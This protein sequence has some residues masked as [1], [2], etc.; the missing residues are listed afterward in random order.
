MKTEKISRGLAALLKKS[1]FI[2]VGTSDASGSPSVASKFLLKVDGNTVYLVD[3]IKGKTLRNVRYNPI[4]SLSVMDEDN[5]RGYQI[6]GTVSVIEFGKEFD[7]L[8]L[9]FTEKQVSFATNRIIAGVQQS[10]PHAGAVFSSNKAEVFYRISVTET[11]EIGPLVKLKKE[12]IV[13]EKEIVSAIVGFKSRFSRRISYWTGKNPWLTVTFSLITVLMIGLLDYR[14]GVDIELSILLLFPILAVT[15]SLGKKVSLITMCVGVAV[16]MLEEEAARGWSFPWGIMVWNAVIRLVFFV[17]II[18]LVFDLKSRMEKEKSF[19]RSDFLTGIANS[20]HF[21]DLLTME[22]KRLARDGRP[23][24]LAYIDVDNFKSV[25][26]TFGHKAGDALLRLIA[27][28]LKRSVRE[29]DAVG[30][31]GGD[32]F[33]LLLP[34]TVQEQARF[35]LERTNNSL[36]EAVLKGR[37]DVTFSIG[38]VTFDS[39]AASADEAISLADK[40]MYEAK[41]TGKNSIRYECWGRDT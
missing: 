26:D 18:N 32:E 30:R 4:I 5:L 25:N 3:L 24:T 19:A 15:I 16:W 34:L 35:V 20:R 8:M 33:A 38:S 12:E 17:L 37:Y 7:L 22:L 9:E 2:S 21:S 36:L 1:E 23:F 28:T 27:D 41:Q 10:K 39:A 40:V 6:N 31:L 14:V 29:I 11:L 13:E